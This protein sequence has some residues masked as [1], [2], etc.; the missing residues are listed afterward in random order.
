LD[1][2]F[3]KFNN[4]VKE[5]IAPLFV[6]YFVLTVLLYN[7]WVLLN[8]RVVNHV[9]VVRLKLSCFWSLLPSIIDLEGRPGG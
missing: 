6:F 8:A 7:V 9:K 4:F 1:A 2:L 3:L 5:L